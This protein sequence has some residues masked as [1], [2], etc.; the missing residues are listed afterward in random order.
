MLQLSCC[1]HA[2]NWAFGNKLIVPMKVSVCAASWGWF[3]VLVWG[4]KPVSIHAQENVHACVWGD[5]IQHAV[6]TLNAAHILPHEHLLNTHALCMT[7]SVSYSRGSRCEGQY[8]CDQFGTFSVHC[9]ALGV[10]LSKMVYWQ[11]GEKST[12]CLQQQ[13]IFV[14]LKEKSESFCREETTF[15]QKSVVLF[16]FILGWC[17]IHN[18]LL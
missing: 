1:L 7:A 9:L 8:A 16:G 3:C 2:M 13:W 14:S 18:F 6:N 11:R 15:S 10:H 12:R 5:I 4:P 17:H